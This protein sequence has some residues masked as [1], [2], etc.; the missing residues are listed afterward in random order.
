[1]PQ[2]PLRGVG[3]PAPGAC[4]DAPPEISIVG[5]AYNE[6]E[7][8]PE[9]MDRCLAGARAVGG[10]CE[11]I[12][13]DDGS[14]DGTRRVLRE[15]Q[16]RFPEL[17]TITQRRNQGFTAALRAGLQAARGR[18]IVVEPTD[19]QGH[20]D[21]DLPILI[22]PLRRDEAD[23]VMGY[24]TDRALGT[25]RTWSSRAFN[26]LCRRLFGVSFRDLG[27]VKAFRRE[28]VDEVAVLRSD[29]HRYFAIFAVAEGFRA[30]EVPVRAYERLRGVSSHG[31][32]GFAR[33]PKM[34]FDLF[35]IK[36]LLSFSRR[37]IFAFGAWALLVGSLGIGLALYLVHWKLTTGA[38]S[39]RFPLLFLDA[40]L[41]L[42]ALQLL[43]IGFL[44]EMVVT[45]GDD[46]H[47]KFERG[48]NAAAAG[49]PTGRP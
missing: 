7:N 39:D 12:V 4:A 2:L 5:A 17:V 3:P 36:F 28:V 19:L 10:T 14:T 23:I 21:E 31:R 9:F 11:V 46:L 30:Q 16:L 48:P 6:E 47:R 13:V 27:W 15:L 45:L 37:P 43:A 44:A 49:T 24:K 20:P 8:L 41:L 25:V 35:T 18:F 34:V 42:A 1:M 33:V 26:W 38:I 22:P 32:F 40:V 29:W